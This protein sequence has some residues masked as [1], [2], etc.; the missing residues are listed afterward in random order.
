MERFAKITIATILAIL[1]VFALVYAL[2]Y[3]RFDIN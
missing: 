2:A 3:Y 1:V